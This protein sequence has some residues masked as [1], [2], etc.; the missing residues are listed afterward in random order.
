MISR[1][2]N[3]L[4]VDDDPAVRRMITTYL[5]RHG[6]QITDSASAEEAWRIIA[7]QPSQID[8]L[9][10]DLLM[11]AVSGK[12]LVQRVRE[13]GYG[14]PI[15]FVSGYFMDGTDTC[16]GVDCLRKPLD[17]TA[18]VTRVEAL[19]ESHVPA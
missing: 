6:I 11:P 5:R 1:T 10:T 2:G 3:V 19:I 14:F 12:D 16:A 17:L 18:F 9:I 15:L 8:L 7:A 13:A 4:L